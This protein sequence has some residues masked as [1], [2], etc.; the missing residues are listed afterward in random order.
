LHTR[1]DEMAAHYVAAIREVQ[2]QGPYQIGGWSLGVVIAY[3][4]ARQLQQQGHTV[5]TLALLDQGPILP[6]AKP[7]DDAEYLVNTFGQNIS[8][9]IQKL[10]QMTSDEQIAYV[11]EKARKARWLFPEV[12]LDQ[13]QHFVNMLKTHTEAWRNYD[14]GSYAGQVTLFR[15][16]DPSEHTPSEPDFGWGA[17]A[18]GG[19]TIIDVPGDHLS[20]MHDPHVAALADQLQHCLDAAAQPIGAA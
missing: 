16:E 15:A 1:I 18:L 3:E 6:F 8:L 4:M 14:V 20:M 12:T 11:W 13:F 9:P 19:T 10:R 7:V 5:S 2:P 17:Y